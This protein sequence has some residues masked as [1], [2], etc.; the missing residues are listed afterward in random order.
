MIENL[1][2]TNTQKEAVPALVLTTSAIEN[3]K[4]L[5][6]WKYVIKVL[7]LILVNYE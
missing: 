3:S 6:K 2:T 5:S 4:D 7:Q 1:L